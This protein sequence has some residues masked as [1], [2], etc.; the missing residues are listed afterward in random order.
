MTPRPVDGVLWR[1]RRHNLSSCRR[2]LSP[3]G[4]ERLWLLDWH[5]RLGPLL[6]MPSGCLRKRQAGRRWWSSRMVCVRVLPTL[7]FGKECLKGLWGCWTRCVGTQDI[8]QS[9]VPLPA[10]FPVLSRPLDA[11]LCRW[12]IGIGIGRRW[13]NRVRASPVEWGVVLFPSCCKGSHF[14]GRCNAFWPVLRL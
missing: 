10:V 1:G 7:S 2:N 4:R 14:C 8:R 11:S 9:D 5:G 6:G 12:S 13:C 3:C